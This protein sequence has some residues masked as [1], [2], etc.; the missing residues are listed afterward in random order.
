MPPE[1]H[2]QPLLAYH[3]LSKHDF[4]AYAPGPGYLDWAN[5]PD[6]F[7]RFPGA[8]V[9][10]LEHL[11]PGD[12][13]RY[14]PAFLPGHIAPAPVDRHSIS[15]L[16]YD[17]LAL[18][19][20]KQAGGSRWALRVNPS[21][22]N[23]HPTEGYLISG[24]L[25]GISET[26]FVA[27]YAPKE[28]GLE[29]RARLR[30]AEWSALAAGLP[31]G[32]VLVGLSSIL[33]RETWKYGERGYRYCQHDVGHALGALSIAAAGLGWQ[34]RLVDS[35][36]TGECGALLGLDLEDDHV[37]A[38]HPDCLVAVWPQDGDASPIGIPA[39][40]LLG[41]HPAWAGTPNRLSDENRDWRQARAVAHLARKPRTEPRESFR[42][43]AGARLE[44]EES[45]VPLRRIIHQRRSAVDMD[46]RT[47]ITRA[48]FYQMLLK[49]YPG[50]VQIPYS[51][52]DW[53][54][55]VHLALFVH[56]VQGVDPGLY[57]LVRDPAEVEPLRAA[58]R[59]DFAW[60]KPAGCPEHL[61]FFRL[62]TGDARSAAA[63][64]SCGQD[65]AADGCFAAAMLARFR[66]LADYGPW[67]YPRL[68]WE[69][70]LLGQVLYLEA[71]ASGIRATGIGCFFDDPV[72]QMLGLP[73]RAAAEPGVYQS[74]YHFT[75]GGPLEDPRIMQM[76][77][78]PG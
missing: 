27:H 9:A 65:I 31:A 6:P 63:T 4:Q 22:G 11:P 50:P 40:A 61:P 35:L 55:Q 53:S 41:F 37:E 20:W 28:H 32:A 70:G 67:F 48:A 60:E 18:S 13:P 36:S 12:L 38:E 16:F 43:I 69:C 19:A 30:P 66:S 76:P 72:H 33:W 42:G 47:G 78:Y 2:L 25:A 15:Q 5:Q 26:P 71:E 62:L 14:E 52:L 3:E 59:A 7:R 23:L 17:S 21:S 24:P 77:P 29:V 75:V 45:P 39:G 57:V 51:T 54:P 46:G 64:V 1:T 73:A 68:F 58:M 8:P 34:A 56:R 10:P 49:A 74:L 44:V